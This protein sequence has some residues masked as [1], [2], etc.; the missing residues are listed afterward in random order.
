MDLPRWLTPLPDAAQQRALD[1]W[2][3]EQHAIPA[4]T[5]MER[6]GAALAEACAEVAPSGRIVV[7][8]G[9]GNNGGDGQVAARLL[10]AQLR[11]VEVVEAGSAAAAA[12]PALLHGAAAV[13]D[14]LLGTGFVGKPRQ[15]VAEA[16]AAINGARRADA[17][18]RVLACDV[19]S[20]VDASTGEVSAAAVVAD[21]TVSFH[22][23]KP[24][25]WIAPGKS[26]AGDVRV[27]DIGIPDAG[28]P[29]VP[30][31]GL[32]AAEVGDAIPRRGPDS[33]K[34]SSGSVLVVGGSAAFSGAPVLAALG[35][36][37][38]GA[39]YV[40]VAA[41]ASAVPMI[42]AKVLEVMVTAFPDDPE[43]GPRRGSSRI[44]VQRADRAQ[45]MVLGPG[46]GRLAATQKFARDVAAHAKLPLVL[47]ADGLIAHATDDGL[48]QLA[49]R[50]DP[51]VLTPHSGELARLLGISSAE[52]DAKR[53]EHVR[54]AAAR[55][56]SVVVLKGDDTLVAEPGGAV[57]ISR[58]GAPALATAG[59]GDVLAGVLGA[60]LAKGVE[61]FTA[62]C[63]AVLIHVRAGVLAADTVGLEGV[64]ASD[65]IG[66]LPR[67][68]AERRPAL[69]GEL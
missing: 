55:A 17:A 38:A 21:L 61:P 27:V 65:V 2:A 25:L 8:C 41:P 1:T 12:L 6:A 68:R 58:G 43:S 69:A 64:I 33:N 11:E 53:L 13:I 50:S 51:T 16:I 15:P 3:I 20:G 40:T 56:G 23:A 66:A 24:G 5:L 48:E 54:A 35:A 31:I 10:R 9:H 28:Q 57:A 59:T 32:I 42:A 30:Q 4:Q 14:A 45:A 26:H 18:L 34:F 47:D 37:R 46:L 52:V 62:A 29:V 63:A 39:G 22:A 7:V 60:F 49:R 44:A 36:T 67:V 19:P